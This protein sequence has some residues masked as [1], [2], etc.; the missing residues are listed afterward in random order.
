MEQISFLRMQQSLRY[1]VHILTFFCGLSCGIF[2]I[3]DYIASSDKMI[4]ESKTG[5]NL[6]GNIRGPVEVLSRH[7]P[8]GI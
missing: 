7:L 2:N 4:D 6:E 3:A 5:N 1:F 8:E